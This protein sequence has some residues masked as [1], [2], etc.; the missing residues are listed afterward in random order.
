MEKGNLIILSASVVLKPGNREDIEALMR[1][2][3]KKRRDKQPLEYPS[4]G[5]VFKRKAGY[6]MGQIIEESGLKGY[7]IGGAMV[8]EKHAGFI[9][10]VGGATAK[11][12]LLLVDYI[13]SV[14]L[15]NYGF[16]A[17]CEIR[18]IS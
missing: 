9:I 17:E 15:K 7:R 6:F 4:A 18:Y 14:I 16:E 10:N 3:M 8:S 12:V 5:S 2:T 11:D 1:E 13:K